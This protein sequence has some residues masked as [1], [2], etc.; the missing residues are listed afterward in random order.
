[1]AA[2]FSLGKFFG[3]SDDDDDYEEADTTEATSAPAPAH[4]QSAAPVQTSTNTNRAKVVSMNSAPTKSSKI[5]IFEPRIY[6]DAEE[7]GKNL[8]DNKAVI[9]NFDRIGAEQAKRIVDFLN[10]TVFAINGEIQRVGEQIFLCTPP[11]F[12]I[13]GGD[14]SD[15]MHSQI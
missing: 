13:D 15:L 7:V 3:M 2:K 8:V 10:G 1:M 5:I 14:I 6:S 9:V 12:E 11:N 4:R